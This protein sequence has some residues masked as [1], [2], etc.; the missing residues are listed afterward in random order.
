MPDSATK[1]SARSQLELQ[2]TALDGKIEKFEGMM[3]ED[4][5]I[6]LF[7]P[8]VDDGRIAEVFGDLATADDVAV[9]VPGVGN[10][11]DNYD[12]A[13]AANLYDARRGDTA[14]I[15][16]LGYDTPPGV[17]SDILTD[18]SALGVGRSEEHAPV[19]KSFTE[20]IDATSSAEITIVAHSYGTVL[21]TES[22]EAGMEVDRVILVGSPGVAAANAGVFNGAEVFAIANEG[23]PIAAQNP[24]GFGHL[25]TAPSDA[26]FD[27]QVL[28]GN[29]SV[30][31][32]VLRDRLWGP[33][34]LLRSRDRRPWTTSLER[35]R[36]RSCTWR[37]TE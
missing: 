3:S 8:T 35:S 1:V 22:A 29:S 32:S 18:P 6:M 23:D 30:V 37:T 4:R 10:G 20:G 14:T 31:G 36:H 21:A 5:Q 28:E 34:H 12:P 27:A 2:L 16:W 17:E 19:L 25:G 9:V 24:I 7:D 33:Q 11:L 15:M 26:S 13:N